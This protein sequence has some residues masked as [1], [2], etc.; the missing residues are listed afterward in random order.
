MKTLRA[1]STISTLAL[2]VQN[3]TVG[4]LTNF[5]YYPITISGNTATISP[6]GG[7]L[8]YGKSYFVTIDPGVFTDST[9]F[10]YA[11]ISS[12]S[13]WAFSTKTASPSSSATQYVVAADG[14]GDFY[15]VQGALD[16][17]PSGNTTRA[18]SLSAKAPTSSRSILR[19]TRADLPRR[20][21][22]AKRDRLSE[23]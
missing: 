7:V 6:R 20:G 12:N 1:A 19:Q 23:Q 5:N 13:G 8:T 3:K 21:S 9:G 18:P 14:S 10:S 22:R 4:G 17:I 16:F 11:G 2:P 15:T